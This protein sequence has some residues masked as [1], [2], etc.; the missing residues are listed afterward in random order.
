MNFLEFS[1]EYKFLFDKNK[2][3]YIEHCF[4]IYLLTD[5]DIINT[6]FHVTRFFSSHFLTFFSKFYVAVALGWHVRQT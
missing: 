1:L 5:T 6:A 3:S 4:N 2:E